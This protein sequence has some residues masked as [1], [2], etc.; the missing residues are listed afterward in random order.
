MHKY[1]KKT[2]FTK[3]MYVMKKTQSYTL[4]LGNWQSPSSET[5]GRPNSFITQLQMA[6][7]WPFCR[8]SDNSVTSICVTMLEVFLEINYILPDLC[9]T[10]NRLECNKFLSVL[11]EQPSWNPNTLPQTLAW[12]GFHGLFC[13]PSLYHSHRH[14]HLHA[15]IQRDHIFP[16]ILFLL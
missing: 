7:A 3:V 5:R 10:D 13:S 16:A 6:T 4:E 1:A 15:P 11:F 12:K 8:A 14:G 2:N 9:S